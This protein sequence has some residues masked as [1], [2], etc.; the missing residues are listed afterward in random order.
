MKI[1]SSILTGGI[2]LFSLLAAI[3]WIRSATAVVI[4]K[5]SETV[6]F[7][8]VLSD[9]VGDPKGTHPLSVTLD[10]KDML[11]TVATQSRWNRWAAISAAIAATFQ[12][13]SAIIAAA[14]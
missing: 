2:V 8:M 10:G 5:G 3:D 14:M 13:F 7:Q 4:A 11:A 12:L 9:G 6:P 1:L